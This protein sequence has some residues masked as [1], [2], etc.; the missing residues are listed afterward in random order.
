VTDGLVTIG[1]TINN[2]WNSRPITA[3]SGPASSASTLYIFQAPASYEAQLK[4]RF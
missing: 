1:I 3:Q 2:P 4:I